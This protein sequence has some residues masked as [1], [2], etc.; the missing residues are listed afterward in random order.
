MNRTL[1]FRLLTHDI[2]NK[3]GK[4]IDH[5]ASVNSQLGNYEIF[6]VDSTDFG[7]LPKSPFAYWLSTDLLEKLQSFP[8]FEPSAADVRVG[9]QTGND[10]QF[11][12]AIWEINPADLY[13]CY[14]PTDGSNVCNLN[15]PILHSYL[16]RRGRGNMKWA[17]HVKSGASQPWYS[18]M[19]VVVDWENNGKALKHFKKA[20]IRNETYYFRPG[21][22]WT[23]RSIRL[24]PYLVPT[25]CIPTVSRYMAFPK[26]G[27][28]LISMVFCASNLATGYARLYGEKF[29]WPKFL[30]DTMKNIPWSNNLTNLS[31]ELVNH[32][33]IE[34][35]NRRNVYRYF[36]PFHD[37]CFANL[38]VGDNLSPNSIGF[39]R[40]SLIGA[41]N[42]YTVSNAY[43]VSKNELAE[44]ERDMLEAIQTLDDRKERISN[45]DSEEIIKER[46]NKDF[47][48]DFTDEYQYNAL[49]QYAMGCAYGRWD[50]RLA[51][52]QKLVPKPIEPFAPLPVCPP[53]TLIGPDGLPAISGKIVSEEWLLNRPNTISIPPNGSVIQMTIP[54]GDFPLSIPW[55]GIIPI[56][57]NHE[58]GVTFRIQQVLE[59]LFGGYSEKIIGDALH[60]LKLPSLDVYFGKPSL[61]FE[62]H[63]GCYTKSNRKAPIYWQ[64]LSSKRNYGFWLYYHRMEE[65]TLFKALTMYADPKLNLEKIRLTDLIAHR[66]PSLTGRERRQLEKNISDQE[67]LINELTDFRNELERIARLRLPP[68]ID[69]GVLI[70]IAPLH[71]LVPWKEADKMWKELVQGKHQWS[72]MSHRMRSK[73]LIKEQ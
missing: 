62:F 27:L 73:G 59:A 5:V 23:L 46:E 47:V 43:G 31:S 63:K 16:S 56:D 60:A 68:D 45:K 17:F 24:I 66:D 48:L 14:Y 67:A 58:D 65:D 54:D 25:N 18:P 19:T 22:S 29:E 32:I 6:E 40:R 9:L 38:S 3:K 69:D 42:E 2:P 7:L 21:F 35:E 4:L 30:V 50:I 53:G 55:H 39:S 36:E 57:E 70:S 11:V 72:S 10:P 13:F 37:F 26:S 20:V 34:I 64:L 51:L 12:R 49:L 71:N 52:D 41:H 1:F 8:T 15:D 44:L 61:F 33:Q 28:E